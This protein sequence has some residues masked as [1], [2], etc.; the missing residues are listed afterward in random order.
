VTLLLHYIAVTEVIP[1]FDFI[2][3]NRL[4]LQRL[5]NLQDSHEFNGY[6]PYPNWQQSEQAKYPKFG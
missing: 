6:V 2:V 5:Q 3:F 4:K 1:P